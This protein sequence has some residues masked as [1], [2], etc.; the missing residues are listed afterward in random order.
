MDRMNK[1]DRSRIDPVHP[2]NPVSH[3]QAPRDIWPRMKHGCDT[4]GEGNRLLPQMESE[5]HR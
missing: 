3:G 5:F 2:V 4:D 1:M